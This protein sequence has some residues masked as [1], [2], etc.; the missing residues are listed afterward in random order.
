[1]ATGFPIARR[2]CL[3]LSV[4]HPIP[5]S[6]LPHP[7]TGPLPASRVFSI[8]RGCCAAPFHHSSRVFTPPGRQ[9]PCGAGP[10]DPHQSGDRFVLLALVAPFPPLPLSPVP[11]P[12]T[13]FGLH[14]ASS[15]FSVAQGRRVA[16]ATPIFLPHPLIPASRVFTPPGRQQPSGVGPLDPHPSWDRFVCLAPFAP[17]SPPSAC[18]VCSL[19]DLWWFP[20]PGPRAPRYPCLSP[21]WSPV[22]VVF[23]FCFARHPRSL[24]CPFAPSRSPAARRPLCASRPPVSL[25]GFVRVFFF[26]PPFPA[27]PP[28]LWF[29]PPCMHAVHLGTGHLS[30]LPSLLLSC[31]I[32]LL[33]RGPWRSPAMPGG[34]P[35]LASHSF[36]CSPPSPLFCPHPAL[37][38]LL[39]C[40][41]CSSLVVPAPWLYLARSHTPQGLRPLFR[42]VG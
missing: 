12:V 20:F 18:V 4:S 8:P 16:L 22:V 34:R 26:A 42:P 36:L 7:V 10:P 5:W 28:A 33:G 41:V 32:A 35:S 38:L 3:A 9:Q 2:C 11:C 39:S 25:R 21:T 19:Q 15:A 31:P 37:L 27:V 13:H 40:S 29:A 23:V 14:F 24:I 6:P 17:F 1:M 30:L